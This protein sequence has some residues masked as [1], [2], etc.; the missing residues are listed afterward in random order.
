MTIQEFRER[1]Q[2]DPAVDMLGEGG[3][4]EVYKAYDSHRDRWVAVKVSKVKPG[5]DAVR[6]RK[7]CE[8]IEQLPTHPNIAFYEACYTFTLDTGEYDFGILQYYNDGSLHDLMGRGVVSPADADRL[9][10]G[11]LSGLSFLHERGVIHRDMKPR[12]VLIA[13]GRNGEFIP[14]ITDFGIS[15]KVDAGKSAVFSNSMTGAGT[16]AYSSPEQLAEREIRRNTDLWSFGV[17]AYQMLTGTLPFDTGTHAS[18]SEAG[19]M[20]LFSQISRGVLP[21]GINR[22]PQPWRRL[23]GRCVVT[24]VNARVHNCDE[25]LRL[26]DGSSDAPQSQQKSAVPLTDE[27]TRL[28]AVGNEF[29]PKGSASDKNPI[30]EVKQPVDA[31]TPDDSTSLDAGIP[32]EPNPVVPDSIDSDGYDENGHE[33]EY[34]DKPVIPHDTRL[35]TVFAWLTYASAACVILTFVAYLCDVL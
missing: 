24:D 14:K 15:K 8:M 11:I 22:V 35:M 20:T 12:N 17:I 3:F 5:L 26:L 30:D 16:L 1:Y 6:L 23:I 27:A 18:T 2:Y 21:D 13:R 10:R 33:N 29:V 31:S 9:L 4:G 28:D 25:A 7:E 32:I 34:N 19:R